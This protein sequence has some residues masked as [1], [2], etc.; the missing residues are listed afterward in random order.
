MRVVRIQLPGGQVNKFVY[1]AAGMVVAR[2]DAADTTKADLYAYDLAG[3]VRTLTNRENQVVSFSYDALGRLLARTGSSLADALFRYSSTGQWVV[4]FNAYAYDSLAFDQAGRLARSYQQLNGTTFEGVYTHDVQNR[5]THRELTGNGYSADLRIHYRTGTGEV[6]SLCIV[7]LCEHL[8][9]TAEW[10]PAARMVVQDGA[11]TWYGW[12]EQSALHSTAQQGFQGWGMTDV[13]HVQAAFGGNLGHDALGRVTSRDPTGPAPTQVF[14]YDLDGQLTNACMLEASGCVNVVNGS[15]S[16]AYS[17]DVSGNL[18]I[19]GASMEMAS[20]NRLARYMCDGY[21]YDAN[22]NRSTVL[23][24]IGCTQQ[25][26]WSYT[27]DALSQLQEVRE[28]TQLKA[29]FQYDAFGRRVAKTTSAGT[30]RYVYDADHVVLDLNAS[31]AVTTEYAWRP[32]TD[33]LFAIKKGA[34]HGIAITDPASGTVRGVV[35]PS[36]AAIIKTYPDRPWGNMTV[37]TGVV[38][39]YRMAGREFDAETGLYYMR[40]RY[41]DPLVGRFIS[42]DPSGLSGG[43]NLYAYAANDPV[44]RRDPTGASPQCGDEGLDSSGRDRYGEQQPGTLTTGATGLPEIVVT[45]PCPDPIGPPP[46]LNEAPGRTN[47]IDFVAINAS[48]G[49]TSSEAGPDEPTFAG[50]VKDVFTDNFLTTNSYLYGFDHPRSS[51]ARAVGSLAAGAGAAALTSSTG[52]FGLISNGGIRAGA[53]RTVGTLAAGRIFVGRQA[54]GV[55]VG[56]SG[57]ASVA[58]NGA[59]QVGIILGSAGTAIGTCWR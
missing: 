25:P 27:W 24:V 56:V 10:L 4:G 3:Q 1:N 11:A 8:T 49:A 15:L 37:D 2:H 16:P 55:A 7:S 26:A 36:G 46:Y 35:S 5:L 22:G 33:R 13:S 6:D 53:H 9:I 30:E 59:L 32:G 45:A 28:G 40:G 19:A 48:L 34:W 54:I 39:R 42:E 17:Y 44:T 21:Q 12:Y 43:P 20:G 38:I 52:L 41:Y 51:G 18:L 14:Q 31:N 23:S 47:A 57:A 50:C 29:S 58:V